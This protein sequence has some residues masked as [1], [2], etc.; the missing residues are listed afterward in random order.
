MKARSTLQ[1]TPTVLSPPVV[2]KEGG[3]VGPKGDSK[4][5][6]FYVRMHSKFY[7]LKLHRVMLSDYITAF[8]FTVERKQ[9]TR[10]QVEDTR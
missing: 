10:L 2:P 3:Q 7:S 9:E 5:L 1:L 8:R 4:V 6:V